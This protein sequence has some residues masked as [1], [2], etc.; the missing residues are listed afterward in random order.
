LGSSHFA[1]VLET[2]NVAI[3]FATPFTATGISYFSSR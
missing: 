2:K 1:H 3:T